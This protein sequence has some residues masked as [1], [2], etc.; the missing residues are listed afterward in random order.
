MKAPDD[1]PEG[2]KRRRTMAKEKTYAGVLGDLQRFHARMEGSAAE[3]PHLEAP[4]TRLGTALSRAQELLKQQSTLAA[5][6]QEA[7]QELR[8]LI[9]EGQRLANAMRAMMKSHFGIRAEKLVE[10]GLQP[11]RG[12]ARKAKPTP[13]APEG[14][15]PDTPTSP[16][17]TPAPT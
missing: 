8:T 7:S 15:T 12:K 9:V 1:E 13:D 16:P 10:F 2:S 4:R 11:F 5:A 14:P 3:I 17:V 6:K